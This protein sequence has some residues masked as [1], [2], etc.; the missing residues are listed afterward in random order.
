MIQKT[1]VMK[2]NDFEKEMKALKLKK[3]RI[4]HRERL[5]KDKVRKKQ[6]GVYI[7]IG[8]AAVKAR[9]DH[10][11]TNARLG[12]FLEVKEMEKEEGTIERWTKK[13]TEALEKKKSGEAVILTFKSEPEKKLK[14]EI[15]EAGLRWNRF[16]KEWQGYAKRVNLEKLLKNTEHQ[17]QT[18]SDADG[19][20]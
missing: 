19:N 5:L 18:V 3:S 15:R 12:A 11:N 6:T 7:E 1:E 4:D 9:I 20:S 13:G 14:A 8:K 10:L 2:M 17:I 16:R